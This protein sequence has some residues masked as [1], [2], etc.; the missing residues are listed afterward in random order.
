MQRL[1]DPD[2]E[3][4]GLR[5]EVDSAL[6][7]AWTDP[8]PGELL[9]EQ[10]MLRDGDLEVADRLPVHGLRADGPGGREDRPR[11]QGARKEGGPDLRGVRDGPPRGGAHQV[12]VPDR[13]ST[14][15]GA[16][17]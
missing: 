10:E 7:D 5:E 13:I 1:P 11:L 4:E 15:W 16:A 2:R 3:A 17:A 12:R 9:Q 6:R 14:L 8:S